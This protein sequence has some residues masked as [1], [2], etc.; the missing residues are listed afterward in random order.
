MNIRLKTVLFNILLLLFT[1]PVAAQRTQGSQQCDITNLQPAIDSMKKIYEQQG[2]S[3]VREAALQ[4]ESQYEFPIIVPLTQ[5][6]WYQIIFVGDPGSRL[7]EV[8]MYDYDEKEVAYQKKQW[9]DVDGNAIAFRY[10]PKFSE[11]HIIRPVQIH[12]KKKEL[13]GYVILMKRTQ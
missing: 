8:R 4:M 7:F 6:E 13:C 1:L 2:Y 5:N 3:I 10:I 9:G 12:K 11:Y